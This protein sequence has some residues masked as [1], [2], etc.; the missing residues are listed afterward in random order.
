MV[1]AWLLNSVN[2]EISES[3]IYCLTASKLW[4]ELQERYGQLDGAKLFQLQRDLNN[5]TQGT[6][7]V[8]SYFDKLKK[9]WDQMKVLNTFMACGCDC[10]CGAKTHNNKMNEDMKLMQFLIGLNEMYSGCRGDIL[11]MKPLPSINQAYSIILHEE[12]QREVKSEN[13]VFPDSLVSNVGRWIEQRGNIQPRG[14]TQITGGNFQS[15]GQKKK[16]L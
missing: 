1:I 9:L 15:M 7:D 6:N 12:F 2:K 5:L 13:M 11:M 16:P 10:K 3:V 4:N 8:A 14:N